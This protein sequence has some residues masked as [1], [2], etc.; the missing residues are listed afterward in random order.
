MT[1]DDEKLAIRFVH[2]LA[3]RADWD[4]QR[5]PHWANLSSEWRRIMAETISDFL[6][7]LGFTPSGGIAEYRED[8][9]IRE[10]CERMTA[11]Q[12]LKTYRQL[13]A[14]GCRINDVDHA[15]EKLTGSRS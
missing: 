7:E 8:D 1:A 13:Y 10:L 4:G 14:L 6:A 11:R 5:A 2:L 15:I 12:R 3:E 9:H